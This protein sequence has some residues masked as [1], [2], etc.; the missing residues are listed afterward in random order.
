MCFSDQPTI[1][2]TYGPKEY[3]RSCFAVDNSCSDASSAASSSSLT[4]AS[5]E[6][7]T[8][9]VSFL[10]SPPPFAPQIALT[11]YHHHIVPQ[12][13]IYIDSP[14][15]AIRQK[16]RRMPPPMLKIDTS[17]N[18]GLGPLFLTGNSIHHYY[19]P[20]RNS[21][22][23]RYT[24]IDSFFTHHAVSTSSGEDSAYPRM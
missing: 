19:I 16:K 6:S 15:V 2:Y 12:P 9:P 10:L 18:N 24:A 4:C 22:T 7:P 14:I 13:I 8:T 17:I 1:L 5:S 3:D 11:H 23:N 20:F 21:V